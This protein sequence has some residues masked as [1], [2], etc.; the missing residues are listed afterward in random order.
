KIIPMLSYHPFDLSDAAHQAT[1]ALLWTRA[2]GSSLALSPR[3]MAYNTRRSRDAQ[4]VGQ[5]AQM[6]GVPVGFVLAS[7]YRSSTNQVPNGWVDAIAVAPEFQ[8]QGI[9]QQLL[10]WAE[11]WLR[12]QGCTVA[13][14]GASL[15]WFA[16][17]TFA[18]LGDTFFLKRGYV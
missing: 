1:A 6:D 11:A 17:G 12:A 8:R 7:S 14:L 3:A 16:P 15:R 10:E 2:C 18:D 4:Q 5:F 13:R 9:G